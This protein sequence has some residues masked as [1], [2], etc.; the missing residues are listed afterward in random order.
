M[1]VKNSLKI[2]KAF[3]F[4]HPP[5]TNKFKDHYVQKY[6]L[7]EGGNIVKYL[8]VVWYPNSDDKTLLCGVIVFIKQESSKT[9]LISVI[10]RCEQA[11][12]LC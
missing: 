11:S 3:F 7:A 9:V 1:A 12:S 4:K 10:W 5:E 8:L 2:Q 6:I